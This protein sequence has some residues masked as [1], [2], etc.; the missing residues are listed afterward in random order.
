MAGIDYSK[1]S[2]EELLEYLLK[3]SADLL[4]YGK[5]VRIIKQIIEDRRNGKVPVPSGVRRAKGKYSYNSELAFDSSADA[6]LARERDVAIGEMLQL[7]DY[8]TGNICF[9]PGWSADN[10]AWVSVYVTA[11][12]QTH[13]YRFATNESC[14][15]AITVLG[16]R[17]LDLIY[18]YPVGPRVAPLPPPPCPCPYPPPPQPYPPY[19]PCPPIPPFPSE[20]SV[21]LDLVPV[22][23]VYEYGDVIPYPITMTAHIHGR[24]NQTMFI[25]FARDDQVIYSVP[26]ISG[27]DDSYVFSYTD[28]SK[29][30]FTDTKFDVA[31]IAGMQT[32]QDTVWYKFGYASYIGYTSDGEIPSDLTVL[33]KNSLNKDNQVV[34]YTCYGKY[35]CFVYPASWGELARIRD[36]NGFT[37]TQT[38]KKVLTT[39]RVKSGEEISYYV[40]ILDH[41]VA[42]DEFQ[43][44]F[45]F[46]EE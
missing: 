46:E 6:Q 42:V 39:Y 41:P 45:L 44:K 23:G 35:P 34:D 26:Y 25:Q 43:I 18:N 40:Y 27:T 3:Y 33:H 8:K 1:L 21:K 30:I 5:D 24:S 28:E 11:D 4:T 12:I 19:P 16:K 37:I 9:T 29:P 14:L 22:G 32:V 13:P 31:L 15:H 2:T 38:F 36:E 20:L 10:G 17:K 7:C